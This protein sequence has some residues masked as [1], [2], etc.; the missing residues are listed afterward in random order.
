MIVLM[1]VQYW[2]SC[3]PMLCGLYAKGT[4]CSCNSGEDDFF[5]VMKEVLVIKSNYFG[6]G[7]ALR[8]PAGKLSGIRKACRDDAELALNDVLNLWLQQ[9]YNVE[10]FGLPTW[11]M[12]V[13][14]VDDPAGGNAQDIAKRIASNHPIGESI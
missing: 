1:Q 11:R 7:R 12:L 6:L 10:R 14:A 8:L 3:N 5:D 13:M 4:E 2:V 9:G